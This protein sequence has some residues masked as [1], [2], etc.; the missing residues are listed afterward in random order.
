MFTKK[1]MAAAAVAVASLGMA[2]SAQAFTNAPVGT[3]VQGNLVSP[4][5]ALGSFSSCTSSSV[6][7]AVTVDSGAGNGGVG[8]V[9]SAS[10]GGC[11]VFS[12]AATVTPLGLPWTLAV[13]GAGQMTLSNVQ[14][15]LQWGLLNCTYGP[16]TVSGQYNSPS[17]GLVTLSG[18]LNRTAGSSLCPATAAVSGQY[19]VTV[20]SSGAVVVL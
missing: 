9:T 15:R 13:N 20:T 18:T 12:S 14:V 19:R 1:I 8:N 5:V 6:S 10:F 7:G 4:T 3:A 11:T 2:S 16:G 17:A